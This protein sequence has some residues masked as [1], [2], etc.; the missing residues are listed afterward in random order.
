MQGDRI[1]EKLSLQ[2]EYNKLMGGV[3]NFDK[4][5]ASYRFGRQQIVFSSIMALCHW[6]CSSKQKDMLWH[7]QYYKNDSGKV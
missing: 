4:F 2:Q 6:H 3:D 5:F 1:V 7:K